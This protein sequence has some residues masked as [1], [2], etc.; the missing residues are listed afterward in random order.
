M[1]L[2]YLSTSIQSGACLLPA[3]AP[4]AVRFFVLALRTVSVSISTILPQLVIGMTM[5]AQ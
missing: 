1:I 2:Q 4:A 5:R 3:V